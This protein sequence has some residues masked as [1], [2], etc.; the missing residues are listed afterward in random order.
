[1]VQT[2]HAPPTCADEGGFTII[3]VMVAMTLFL[4]VTGA[5]YGLMRTARF[6]RSTTNQRVEI[7]QSARN[8]LNAIT[9]DGIN[10]GYRFPL[11]GARLPDDKLAALFGGAGDAGTEQDVLSAVISGDNV[12]ANNLVR[13]DG[14]TGR[15]DQVT[16]VFRDPGF[17]GDDGLPIVSIVNAGSQVNLT[18]SSS[19][20]GVTLQSLYI[21]SGSSSGNSFNAIGAATN[22]QTTGSTPN[23]IFADSDFLNVNEPGAVSSSSPSPIA[24]V[25]VPASLSRIAFVTYRVLDDGTM[26]RTDYGVDDSAEGGTPDG[27]RDVPVAFGV[28][29]LQISYVLENGTRSDAP[30]NM[31]SVRQIIVTITAQSPETDSRMREA[32]GTRPYRHRVTL[33][34]TINTRN[35]A[36]E[37]RD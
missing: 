36:Y 4:I 6:D 1:M 23:I 28:E 5:V 11:G 21:I 13:A 7:A 17:N 33:S 3:E 31:N 10:A 34:T 29:N 2:T 20:G 35:L 26:V 37:V 19:I 15:T 24:Q 27:R 18:A 8:A 12:N 32:S 16:F 30:A 22:A 25:P 9:R 14:T